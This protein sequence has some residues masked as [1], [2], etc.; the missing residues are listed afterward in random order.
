M[1]SRRALL[2]GLATL[3]ALPS[4]GRAQDRLL[5][6]YSARHYDTDRTL[7]DG[8]TVATGIRLRLIEAPA[9]QLIERI[10]AEGRNSPAD[11]LITVDAGRLERARQAGV[12]QPAGSA[13]LAER[14]PTSLRD[15]AGHWFGIS[16]RIRVMF[17]DRA[18]PLPAG[19]AHYEDLARPEFRGA[20][21]TRSSSN[22]YSIGWTASMIA[23]NGVEAT[24]AWARGV[25]ANLARPP[26][27]GDTDQI[28]A[29]AAGQGAVAVANTYY[30]GLLARSAN[31][32]ERAVAERTA[33]LWPNQA[34]RGA[35]ANVSGAGVVAGAPNREAA[36]RFLEYMSE[37]AAQ[38]LFAEGNMEYPVVPGTPVHPLLLSLGEY[39]EDPV[40]AGQ[41]QAHAAEALRLMQRAGWR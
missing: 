10:R 1:S 18:R 5:N 7:Y 25:V 2:L 35:H 38:R 22:I 33:I 32:E 15:P 28:R 34:D 16:K 36:V 30:W 26:S 9:D 23:A 6:V 21:L 14:V 4:L 39:R 12:L 8:F 40:N 17:H 29:M 13:A 31:A 20:I 19:L 41:L 11:V 37:P 27:G 24:E 3:P